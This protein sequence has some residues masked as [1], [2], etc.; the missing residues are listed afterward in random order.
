MLGRVELLFPRRKMHHTTPNENNDNLVKM[1]LRC[2]RLGGCV[3]RPKLCEYVIPAWR[4]TM[5]WVAALPI[6]IVS[7]SLLL[8]DSIPGVFWGRFLLKNA[9]ALYLFIVSHF[10]TG[11][12]RK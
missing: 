2:R 10:A 3:G 4:D 7:Y 12:L 8:A 6:F 1:S 11:F 5:C 9:A